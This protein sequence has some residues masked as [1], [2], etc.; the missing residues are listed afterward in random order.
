MIKKILF[1]TL[2]MMIGYC[3]FGQSGMYMVTEQ[4][5]QL[6]QT[7]DKVVVTDPSGNTT[8]TNI[9]HFITNLENHDSQLNAIFNQ[10]SSQGY[11]LTP[12]VQG[13]GYNNSSN[14]SIF[15]RTWVFQVP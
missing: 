2:F 5:S 14:V 1:S 12:L 6:T 11:V 13:H 3:S 4:F 10:I 8:T 9:E 7:L 15:T